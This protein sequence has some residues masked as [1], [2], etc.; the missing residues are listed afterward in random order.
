MISAKLYIQILVRVLLIVALSLLAGWSY[1]TQQW[2]FL[3]LFILAAIVLATINLIYFLNSVNRRLFYFFD[4]I[5]NEDSTLSFPDKSGDKLTQQLNNSLNKVNKQ[6]QQIKIENQM[7]EQYFQAILEHAATGIFTLNA[8]RF[9]LHSNASVRKLFSLEVFT[10]LNQ[11]E[12]VDQR[13][14][15][16]L[17]TIRPS[18]QRLVTLNHE[19]GS[20]QLLIK[21]SSFVSGKE[22]L[23]LLSVQDIKNELDEKELDSWLRLIRVL[24]HEIMNSITPITSLSESLAGYFYSEEGVKTPGQIN[25]K[26]IQTTIRGLDVIREQGKGLIAFVESYRKLTRLPKPDKKTIVVKNLLE[27]IRMLAGSFEQ[28]AEISLSYQLQNEQMELF[29]DEKLISQVLINLVKNAFQSNEHN[30]KSQVKIVA[31]IE[32][33]NRP[34]ICVSDN[35]PGIPPELIDEIFVPFFTTREN[36]SGIGL[37]LSRQIMRLHGGSLKVKSVPNIETSFYLTF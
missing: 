2:F 3:S 9:V 5:R 12:R 19:R 21:A 11:L 27:N 26:I 37:S 31:G 36:G 18:E 13:L 35:G 30:P 22:E 23:I 10:H 17:Q 4:A 15:H 14:F 28:G 20:T 29:A 24:M 16:T 1:F 32:E 7:Q 34:V 25:E 8:N 6:I 33:N